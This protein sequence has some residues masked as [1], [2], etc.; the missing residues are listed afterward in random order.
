MGGNRILIQRDSFVDLCGVEVGQCEGMDIG[1]KFKQS[2]GPLNLFTDN[3]R[4]AKGYETAHPEKV[5]SSQACVGATMREWCC[6]F[7]ISWL[8]GL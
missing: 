5:I 1:L 2:T 4:F 8:H 3:V 6:H 7:G